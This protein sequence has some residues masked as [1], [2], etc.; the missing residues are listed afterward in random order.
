VLHCVPPD[1]G[2]SAT[3]GA[4]NR[5]RTSHYTWWTFLPLNLFEQMCRWAN[6]YFLLIVILNQL[7]QLEVFSRT[8]SIFPLAFVLFANFV[9]DGAEDLARHRADR[10]ANASAVLR[11]SGDSAGFQQIRREQVQR[12]DVVLLQRDGEVPADCIVLS[13]SNTAPGTGGGPGAVAA[14]CDT[15]QLDGESSLKPRYAPELVAGV[16]AGST[17]QGQ[18]FADKVAPDGASLSPRDSR[19]LPLPVV[20]TTAPTAQTPP[21]RA[22]SAEALQRLQHL[23]CYFS[24]PSPGF[25]DFRAAIRD[26]LGGSSEEAIGPPNLLLAHSYVRQTRWVLALCLYVGPATKASLNN[27]EP[28]RKTSA[29]ERQ[30]NESVG[31]L[32]VLLVIECLVGA[33][34]EAQFRHR[35]GA[36]S[37]N[38]P[39]YINTEANG[40]SQ[41]IWLIF[42]FMLIYQVMI[43]LALY[44][45][46]E[47][48]RMWQILRI[49]RDDLLV[50]A[51]PD[52]PAMGSRVTI[53]SLNLNEDLGRISFVF[54]DK[55]GTLTE[56]IMVL[57]F[58]ALPELVLPV[59]V[60]ASPSRTGL[61]NSPVPELGAEPSEKR[62]VLQADP[63]LVAAMQRHRHDPRLHQALLGLCLCSSVMPFD[64]DPPHHDEP[65]VDPAASSDLPA[66]QA[67]SPDELALVQ[68]AAEAGVVLASRGAD[69]VCLRCCAAE[70]QS[71]ERDRN[72]AVL[73]VLPFS[74][75][76]RRMS[77]LIQDLDA[78][79]TADRLLFCKGAD[80][81]VISRL[82]P[83]AAGGQSDQMQLFAVDAA[84]QG[85]RTLVV[86]TRPVPAEMAATWSVLWEVARGE[87]DAQAM[88][89]LAGEME[90]D[91]TVLAATAIEDKLQK[92][93]P[94]TL[95][96]LRA[97]GMRIAMLTGD[98]METAIDIARSASLVSYF[99][100]V[101][102]LERE[103]GGSLSAN[104]G[105]TAGDHPST[106]I[107]TQLQ[108]CFMNSAAGKES[109]DANRQPFALALQGS[110]LDLIRRDNGDDGDGLAALFWRV[111]AAAEALVCA[112]LTP[113]QKAFLV[114]ATTR[115]LRTAQYPC[116]GALARRRYWARG[117]PGQL[118]VDPPASVLPARGVTLAIGDGA[119]DVPMLLAADIGVGIVGR[120][121]SSAARAADVVMSRFSMLDRLLT[122]HGLNCYIRLG[123]MV[124]YMLYKNAMFVFVLFW[125]MPFN[126]YSG[127]TAIDEWNLIFYNLVY[128]ALPPI[129]V[130]VFDEPVSWA[131]SSWRPSLYAELGVAGTAYNQPLFILVVL[132]A[133]WESTAIHFIAQLTVGMTASVFEMGV[134]IMAGTVSA[135]T[136]HLATEVHVWHRITIA[137]FVFSASALIPCSVIIGLD[138]TNPLFGLYD[139][140]AAM[141]VFW[142]VSALTFTIALLPRIVVLALRVTAFPGILQR[143]EEA[144]VVAATS[145]SPSELGGEVRPKDLALTQAPAQKQGHVDD[146]GKGIELVPPTSAVAHG[147]GGLSGVAL[148][149]ELEEL[150]IG[151]V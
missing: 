1:M 50:D 65:V 102:L 127:Q 118:D 53:Q 99:T 23:R 107:R 62:A 26:L 15:A 72:F 95:A 117:N 105:E 131:L 104:N 25:T 94:E 59:P 143:A 28:R 55:T 83:G 60:G 129:V 98:K 3:R 56:N 138:P 37:K 111:S 79:P 42:T 32:L 12:G 9:K 19:A 88:A 69:R 77:V 151:R 73:A 29:L 96:R 46:I 58:L 110:T 11:L 64:S 130:A 128:T 147:D 92:G 6:V 21:P 36:D 44:V 27:A 24:A 142:L 82:A 71:V 119:N 122:F 35:V 109:A 78:A 14:W 150:G 33:T 8:T 30:T 136:G 97:A 90:T 74:S 123:G 61:A 68:A 84:R 121:G 40:S 120:E 76:R 54:T 133:L 114:E 103:Q 126:G 51:D 45:S 70:G 16:L 106:F 141:P 85:L 48:V 57:K 113:S 140:V 75:D 20:A 4:P 49:Q 87:N 93:V 17:L 41:T 43:P 22:L 89:R 91:L 139:N 134:P 66:F 10:R 5:Q 148:A 7:P 112:R 67:E 34:G 125:Y 13:S 100:R 132:E 108:S 124:R 145:S 116:E 47:L 18:D 101:V 146:R 39:P 63:H 31:V 115:Q 137:V 38:P 135:A 2:A 144:M 80:D 86:A 52:S 149:V 81:V